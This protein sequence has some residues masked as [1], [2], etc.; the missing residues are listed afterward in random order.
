MK[1]MKL[2]M[3]S[4]LALSIVMAALAT[5][6]A[7][8]F[9]DQESPKAGETLAVAPAQVAIKYDA[10]IE[11]LFAQLQVL[12][13]NG[14]NEAAGAPTISDDSLTL[15]VKLGALPPGVYTVEWAVVCIDSH[16]TNGSYKFTVAGGGT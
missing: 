15:S 8:S 10:P 1:M 7:H 14:K 4:A 3:A 12:D 13:A 5:A 6:Y 9:P 11:K 2:L 16:H